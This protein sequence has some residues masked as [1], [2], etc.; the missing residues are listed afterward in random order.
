MRG[1]LRTVLVLSDR[2]HPWA[3]LRDRLDPELVSVAWSR[4]TA[5]AALLA[6]T[7]PWAIAGTGT[8]AAPELRRL[9]GRLLTCRWVGDEPDWLPVRPLVCPDWLAISTDLAKGLA[10]TLCGVRLAPGRGLSLADGS[11]VS[12]AAELEALL[13]AYP[14]GIELVSSARPAARR[15]NA[16]INRLGLPLQVRQTGNTIAVAEKRR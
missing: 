7:V 3:F 4:P 12:R 1:A 6:E 9:Q 2:P 5:C 10:G 16:L 14:A 15:V 13:A 8:R 11:F